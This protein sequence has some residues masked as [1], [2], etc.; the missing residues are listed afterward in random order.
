VDYSQGVCWFGFF[1][2]ALKSI[3]GTPVLALDI[4]PFSSDLI[5]GGLPLLELTC[6]ISDNYLFSGKRCS[7][8]ILGSVWSIFAFS[9]FAGYSKGG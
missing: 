4:S 2:L 1:S 8:P 3:L 7:Y 6:L 9:K 5:T